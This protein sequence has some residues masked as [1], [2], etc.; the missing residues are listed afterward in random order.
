[1]I[2]FKQQQFSGISMG[3]S[4]RQKTK[5]LKMKALG[6]LVFSVWV[7]PAVALDLG[8][9]QIRSAIGEPLRA[10]IE[11]DQATPEELRTLRAQLAS[12]GEFNEAGMEFNPALNG[13]TASLQTRA[14]G[15]PYIALNGRSPIQENF[16]DL[17]LQTQSSS[18]KRSK[19][20]A[21]LLNSISD[22]A[23]NTRS[24][25]PPS[26]SPRLAIVPPVIA[27]IP[28]TISNLRP[29]ETSRQ[30]SSSSVELNSDRIP[31]YRFAPVDNSQNPGTNTRSFESSPPRDATLRAP[32]VESNVELNAQRIPVYRFAPIDNS[33]ASN[34]STTSTA[35]TARPLAL[36]E[37]ALQNSSRFN[38]ASSAQGDKTITVRSGDTTSQLALRHLS[39]NA[40]LDQMMLA[41][42]KANPDAF[43]QGNVNL[44]KAGAVLRMP[45]ANEA[46]AIPRGEARRTVIAQARDFAE[47]A[48]HLAES[49]L[50]VD[51]K[52][53]RS[54]SG[55]VTAETTKP[56][57][58]TP[59]QDKLTLSK[60]SAS[61]SGAE[62][63]LASEREAKDAADQLAA[64]NKNM[65][66]L[67]ALKQSNSATGGPGE[68]VTTSSTPANP[69]D[70]N[71]TPSFSMPSA[72]LSNLSLKNLSENKHLW[73]WVAALLAAILL[74]AIWARKKSTEPET[75]YAPA[76]DDIP[77]T[78][79]DRINE[80]VAGPGSIPAQ[81]SAIDLNLQPHV[82]TTPSGPNPSFA[83]PAS[84]A[85]PR[86]LPSN[87]DTDQSK[88]NLAAQLLAKGDK[89]LAR[90]LI[91]SVVSSSN[92]DNKASA[93][94]MLGQIR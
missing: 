46:T 87:E 70:A 24:T 68:A 12:P 9:L 33:Q 25:P 38:G 77:E 31:V 93:I 51:S 41:I 40:T 37:P 8:R 11:V 91:L 16:I 82:T 79:S 19:N 42:L 81:M 50:L 64:L 13:V 52:N 56:Q 65:K 73:G 35:S 36:N 90:A 22:R 21:L 1:L 43:I 14:N 57:L 61:G 15:A 3:Q 45:D 18:G 78:R 75:V 59:Q 29:I 94:Q 86:P 4:N 66:E 39:A 58:A 20:Y 28:Q 92:G 69:A 32:A 76:Y 10:E 26:S 44:V 17:I 85:A 55:R 23:A 7:L 71:S 74:F 48:K 6:A 2:V 54:M 47:Y 49:P 67:E 88:L 80:P 27:D 89:D 5:N 63:K 84:N 83:A 34:Q 62:A 53:S 60:S 30:Q 72:S